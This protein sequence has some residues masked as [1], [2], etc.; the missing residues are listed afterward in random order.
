MET[1]G[2]F[3]VIG[4]WSEP[5]AVDRTEWVNQIRAATV[6]PFLQATFFRYYLPQESFHPNYWGQLALR[7]CLRQVYNLFRVVNASCERVVAGGLVGPEPS[8]GLWRAPA[9]MSKNAG[10]A[11]GSANSFVF[12]GA[13][14]LCEETKLA[15]KLIGQAASLEVAP[16]YGNAQQRAPR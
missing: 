12:G 7:S 1:A 16:E 9:F 14:V 13:T 10:A 3:S 4:R 8:M 15:W 2:P 6:N 11:K 5:G